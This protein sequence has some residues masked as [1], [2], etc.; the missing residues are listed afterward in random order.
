MKNKNINMLIIA[1]LLLG[2][3][4][5]S[6][7]AFLT[8]VKEDFQENITVSE[9]GVTEK[10]VKVR[11][12][13]L[14]PTDSREYSINLVCEA[15]GKYLVSIEYDEKDDGGMK[16]FVNV[17]IK[18]NDDMVYEGTL[19]DLIDNAPT[20][21]F[22][23]ELYAKDPVVITINY[24]MP[25]EVGNEAEGTSADFDVIVKIAKI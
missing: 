7:I 15:S 14:N 9:S 8:K 12:L 24:A 11:N 3:I 23:G 25:Y 10:A 20:V 17:T 4:A 6:L 16:E 22:E 5:F 13:S 21:E 1:L 19:I 18:A 2:S